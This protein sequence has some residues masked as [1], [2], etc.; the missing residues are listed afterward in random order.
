MANCLSRR[1]QKIHLIFKIVPIEAPRSFIQVVSKRNGVFYQDE[2]ITNSNHQ[3]FQ[4]PKSN[5]WKTFSF[6]SFFF[7]LT[8]W[9]WNL[10]LLETS[11]RFIMTKVSETQVHSFH[12]HADIKAVFTFLK[13]HIHEWKHSWSRDKQKLLL[14]DPL[15]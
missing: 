12:A 11:A 14:V 6:S 4:D 8:L 3:F 15:S 1:D 2:F 13:K 7:A 9:S 5:I 10:F